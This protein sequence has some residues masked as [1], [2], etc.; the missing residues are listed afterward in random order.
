MVAVGPA[1]S[2]QA[3]LL[4]EV[5]LRSRYQRDRRLSLSDF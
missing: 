4:F 2:S 5:A 1:K 3:D